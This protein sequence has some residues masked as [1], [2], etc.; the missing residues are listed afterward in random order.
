MADVEAMVEAHGSDVL[1]A[2]TYHGPRACARPRR[3]VR[4][5]P[6]ARAGTSIST[7]TKPP[8]PR[9]ARCASSRETALEHRFAGRDPGRPLLFAQRGRTTTSM[10]RTIDLVARAGIDVVSL[11]MCNLFLQDRHAGRTPRWRGVTALHELKAARRQR[12]D[13]QRQHAR[14]V[15]RL[16]RSRHDG[17]LARGRAHPAPRLSRAPIGRP[18]LFDAPARAMGARSGALGVGAPA[19]LILTH[20]RD[21]TELFA[22]PHADRMVL[23]DGAAARRARRPTMPN[24]TPGGAWADERAYDIAAFRAAIGAHQMRGQSGSGASRRAATSTGIRR[25]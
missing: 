24:S 1:G 3:P 9:R 7:S 14:S 17:G 12:H 11:P 23:R 21:F 2:V 16:W 10:K 8:I 22:R 20:A 13:R 5:S 25:F 19:D 15:L 4:L 18:S 6:S